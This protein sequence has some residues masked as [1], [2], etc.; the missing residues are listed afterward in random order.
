MA[1]SQQER[2]E[3][4]H[5]IGEGGMQKVYLANDKLLK[6][7]VAFKIP[8]NDSAIKRFERSAQMSARVNNKHVAKTLD[9]GDVG[10]TNFLI[11]EFIDGMDLSAVLKQYKNGLD[12]YS[13]AR[14]L[15]QTAI[16]V[17]ASHAQ[18][19]VH[20]DLKPSN[21]MVLGGLTMSEF[22][23]TDFGIAKMAEAELDEA[24]EG[25]EESITASQTAVGALPYMSPEMIASVKNA[26]HPTDVW[27]LGAMAYE[28]LTGNKPFGTGLRA[29]TK[30]TSGVFERDIPQ[31]RKPQFRPLGEELVA[32]ISDCLS[33]SP[34]DRPAATELVLRCEKLCYN[35]DPRQLGIVNNFMHDAWGFIQASDGNSIFYHK[36]SIYGQNALASGDRVAFSAYEG[37]QSDRAFP[38]L[39]MLPPPKSGAK[40]LV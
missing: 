29:V 9:Y 14:A 8:K 34:A 31:L 32:I 37:G 1:A 19:V 20:R 39:P 16:G 33:L 3:R 4:L 30:I 21:I 28:L 22:K 18:D 6:S 26:T 35:N 38:V 25:G 12:P 27:S 2:Y 11:E 36:E 24:V 10:D 23:V 15:H 13:V 17:A 5:Q 40:T 7:Q